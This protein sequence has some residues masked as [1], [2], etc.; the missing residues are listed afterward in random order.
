[1]LWS[2]RAFTDPEIVDALLLQHIGV[3]WQVELK[4]C[5]KSIFNSKAWESTYPVASVAETERITGQLG[6]AHSKGIEGRRQQQ[7]ESHFFLSQLSSAADLPSTY[8]NLAD[9]PD[10]S[11]E[12]DEAV[13]TSAVI[14]QKLLHIMTTECDLNRTPYGTRAVIHS[15][16]E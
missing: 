8:D 16:L 6:G 10:P 2:S 5:F 12:G 7:R 4:E 13:P 9:A 3:A 15:D 11:E 1:M 14:K